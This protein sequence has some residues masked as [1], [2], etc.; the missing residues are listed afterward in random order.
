MAYRKKR[1]GRRKYSA[2]SKKNISRSKPSASNQ[3]YQLLSVNRRLNS[4]QKQVN[5]NRVL[6]TQTLNFE[7]PIDGTATTPYCLHQL[8]NISALTDIF[9]TAQTGGAKYTGLKFH[10]DFNIVPDTEIKQDITMTVFI[11]TPRSQK[12]VEECFTSAPPA[13]NFTTLSSNTDYVCED[14][15]AYMNTKRWRIHRVWHHLQTRPILAFEGG[16]TQTWEGSQVNIRKYFTTNSPLKLRSTTG[17]WNQ[18]PDSAMN[19]NQR[20]LLVAFSNNVGTTSPMLTA[21]VL[22]TAHTSE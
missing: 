19:Y 6:T 4:L 12:I 20:L 3:K 10:L 2:S 11:V 17:T 13:Y 18:I 8:N 15:M 5:Q 1:Y 21:N 16:G 9:M 7:L 14:G 22:M